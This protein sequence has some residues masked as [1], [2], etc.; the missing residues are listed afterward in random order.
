MDRDKL[1]PRFPSAQIHYFSF[2][3]FLQAWPPPKK[4]GFFMLQRQ[5]RD[6]R[7]KLLLFYS[8]SISLSSGFSYQIVVADR[9]AYSLK[10]S[11]DNLEGILTV[12]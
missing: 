4:T 10:E 12:Y 1:Q 8:I 6:Q 9:V 5:N 3:E 2:K 11:F 7:E